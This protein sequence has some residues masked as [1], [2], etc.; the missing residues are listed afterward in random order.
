MTKINPEFYFDEQWTTMILLSKSGLTIENYIGLEAGDQN[1]SLLDHCNYFREVL[2]KFKCPIQ[3]VRLLHIAPFDKVGKHADIQLAYDNGIFRLHI[4][5]LTNPK[6]YFL[7]N[8]IKI[9][10]KSGECWYGNFNLPHAV[11]NEG[12]TRRIH[13]VIDL[14]RNE[15]SDLLFNKIGYDFEFEK[16]HRNY[17]REEDKPELIRRLKKIKTKTSNKIIDS[18]KKDLEQP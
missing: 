8:D 14:K 16:K 2:N 15:W 9:K 11:Y 7:I 4:P 13:L 1:Q 10:M 12:P 5:I 18:I 3:S 17:I 6:V